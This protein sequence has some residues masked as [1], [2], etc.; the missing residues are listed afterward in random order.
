MLKVLLFV[1]VACTGMI[2]V[3]AQID[4]VL[5]MDHGPT[6]ELGGMA[7][8][9][10]RNIILALGTTYGIWRSMDGGVT[11]E[12][13][14]EGFPDTSFGSFG[15]FVVN[16]SEL[17]FGNQT[18]QGPVFYRSLDHGRT[19]TIDERQ[20][21]SAFGSIRRQDNV[22]WFAED[23]LLSVDGGRDWIKLDYP[24]LPRW[25][26][27]LSGNRIAIGD[28][29]EW[30]EYDARTGQ[31]AVIHIPAEGRGI[32]FERVG[33]NTFLWIDGRDMMLGT[34][35][36]GS[37]VRIDSMYLPGRNMKVGLSIVQ[38]FRHHDRIIVLDSSGRVGLLDGDSLVALIEH[39]F[40]P[41]PATLAEIRLSFQSIGGTDILIAQY[42]VRGWFNGVSVELVDIGRRAGIHSV[43]VPYLASDSPIL[44][45]NDL[46]AIIVANGLDGDF[47]RIPVDGS[48][49]TL[50]SAPE[51]GTERRPK[52][53]VYDGHVVADGVVLA[54]TEYGRWIRNDR[55]TK[56][57]EVVFGDGSKVGRPSS[58]TINDYV[59]KG[60]PRAELYGDT[61]YTMGTAGVRM[62]MD[63][64]KADT[65]RDSLTTYVHR[66]PDGRLYMGGP[67]RTLDDEWWTDVDCVERWP[68]VPWREYPSCHRQAAANVVWYDGRR[69]ARLR[70]ECE[71]CDDRLRS[72]W[73]LLF[74]R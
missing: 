3:Q 13:A 64:A 23:S 18:V 12:H 29:R 47:L 42:P 8:D 50:S 45:L 21:G 74:Q 16:D 44:I 55:T 49:W 5:R 37:N 30:R 41:P 65:L 10:E 69:S 4:T 39:T 56:T 54:L 59:G 34:G 26:R 19:F 25:R 2:G 63:G 57:M 14:A 71:R 24:L 7:Y 31:W 22:I 28:Y 15:P 51:H 36:G 61:V 33:D 6:F 72:R 17:V 9:S 70:T 62:S 73:N 66:D 60:Y 35:T 27:I 38:M 52:C 68:S 67:R 46:T 58:I 20:P 43:F 11:F 48:S 40:V 53:V 1:M 32:P